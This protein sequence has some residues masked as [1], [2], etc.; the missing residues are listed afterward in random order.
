MSWT[1]PPTKI[2]EA[3]DRLLECASIQ[4]LFT[5]LSAGDQEL[6]FH[7]PD[8]DA[9]TSSLPYIV[10]SRNDED[11]SLVAAGAE[12][13]TGEIEAVIYVDDSSSVGTVE[14][15]ITVA[16]E[17]L[18]LRTEGL[19]IIRARATRSSDTNSAM[20]AGEDSGADQGRLFRTITI[21]MNWEG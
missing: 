3:R 14:A 16:R 5:G 7:Y 15:L 11:Y 8:A 21:T 12:S 9:L 6:R 18:R 20:E 1:N 4:T 19:F 10:L 2:T 13:G 17:L